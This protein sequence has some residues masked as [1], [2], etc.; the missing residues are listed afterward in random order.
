V[1]LFSEN[2]HLP[3]MDAARLLRWS[4]ILSSYHYEIQFKKGSN[5]QNADCL[6]RSPVSNEVDLSNA[7]FIEM[8]DEIFDCNFIY[9]STPLVS[10]I[11]VAENTANDIVL[12][13]VV[14]IV[15]NGN[16]N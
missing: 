12:R 5:I 15:Q 4:I 11:E 7:N 10:Y 16:I 9:L 14:K 8:F 3:K 13:K 6:S 2:K 1:S